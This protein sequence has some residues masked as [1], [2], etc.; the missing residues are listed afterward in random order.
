[1]TDHHAILVRADSVR[2]YEL[3]KEDD[4]TEISD[5][6]FEK[7]GIDDVRELVQKAHQRPAEGDRKLVL[8]RTE[9][10]TLEAQNALLKI[11]EEPPQSTNFVF[12]IPYSFNLID[13]V[14][15]RFS[16][17]DTDRN[18]RVSENTDFSEFLSGNY[19]D[20]LEEIDKAIKKKDLE[21]QK[22]IKQGV[23]DYINDPKTT[24]KSL[25]EL[26]F[27]ARLLLTRGASNKM[28]LEHAALTLPTR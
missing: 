5:N 23:I 14:S 3:E 20:R 2:E 13:T 12:V 9:F 17:I 19:K 26:E 6:F 18:G 11:L 27:V 28:L 1:M 15:S 4:S 10:I 25:S 8:V 16:Q 24:T 21:W 22:K 7:F